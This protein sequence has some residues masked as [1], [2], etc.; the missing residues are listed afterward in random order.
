MSKA[1]QEKESKIR[2]HYIVEVRKKG[3]A[4]DGPVTCEQPRYYK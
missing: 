3:R 2:D 4:L 1:R